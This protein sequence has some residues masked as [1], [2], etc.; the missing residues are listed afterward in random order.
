[1]HLLLW[2]HAE[3]EEGNDDLARKLTPRGKKQAERLAAW[4]AGVLPDDAHVL[5]SPAVRAQQTARV[6][7]REMETLDELAPGA[8][9]QAL[10]QAAGWPDG[11]EW[12][13]VVGHQPALG[14][15][16]AELLGAPES[17][18]LRKAG[19][20]WFE[21]RK[22]NRERQIVLRAVTGPDLV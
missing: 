13:L 7:G 8:D 6:L 2:R 14:M 3:A 21:S 10:L 1:M 18:S 9:A 12:V 17:L 20:M 15:V 16:A 22:R 11:P 5:V 19:L 4:L